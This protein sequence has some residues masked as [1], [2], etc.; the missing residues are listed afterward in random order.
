MAK[1][2]MR[3]PSDFG[4]LLR[5]ALP[6]AAVA[7]ISSFGVF[8]DR[9]FLGRHSQSALAAVTP[10]AILANTFFCFIITTVSYTGTFIAHYYG[11]ERH[12]QAV[13]AFAQGLWL[14]GLSIFALLAALL[15]GNFF[16]RVSCPSDELMHA[17]LVYF[18]TTL[19]A[20]VFTTFSAVFIGY[21]TA[22][23]KAALVA[24][25][26]IGGCLANLVLDPLLIFG[27]KFIPSLGISG[28]G[29]STIVSSALTTDILAYPFLRRTCHWGKLRALLA[30]NRGLSLRILHFAFPNAISYLI[31]TICFY[32]FVC[33]LSRS[34]ETALAVS[35]VCL[36]VN[37]FYFAAIDGLRQAQTALT[38]RCCGANDSPAA[39]RVLINAFKSSG[40]VL[41]PVSIAYFLCGG[42]IAAFF[43]KT[44]SDITAYLKI[45]GI[46]FGI[47]VVNDIFETIQ[48]LLTAALLGSGDTTFSM[49]SATFVQLFFWMPLLALSLALESSIVALWL[50]LAAW[51][52]LHVAILILRWRSGKW[53]HIRLT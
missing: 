16:I 10:A 35:N 29:I 14:S 12:R 44:G 19:P 28:A 11:G 27:W 53:Q 25:A 45:G 6:L 20:Q 24:F 22:E 18:N 2:A 26:A 7:L 23:R 52:V 48:A 31:G 15:I 46:L 17:E 40:Y 34:G 39:N 8:A 1:T 42:Q 32:T 50:S 43:A 13:R 49:K 37:G 33:A 41:I 3:R 5:T 4:E 51:R 36:C 30:F 47:L 38:G 21:Y 9:F